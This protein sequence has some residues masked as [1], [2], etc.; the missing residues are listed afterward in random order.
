ME[1]VNFNMDNFSNKE[2]AEKGIKYFLDGAKDKA[3]GDN[4]NKIETAYNNYMARK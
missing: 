1:K 3:D 2:A 4:Y